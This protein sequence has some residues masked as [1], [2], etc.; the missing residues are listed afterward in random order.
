MRLRKVLEQID[1][2]IVPAQGIPP[3]MNVEYDK[4]IFKRLVNFVT[5]L[6]PE[7]LTKEQNEKLADL[8]TRFDFYIGKGDENDV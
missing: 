4:D 6:K 5:G 1:D 3:S 8:I 2:V 7:Q